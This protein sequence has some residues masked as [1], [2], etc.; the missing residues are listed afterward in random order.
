[1]YIHKLK[2]SYIPPHL[3]SFVL[4]S[5]ELLPSSSPLFSVQYPLSHRNLKWE[6]LCMM[7]NKHRMSLYEGF[8]VVT[9]SE[10]II[11][12][13]CLLNRVVNLQKPQVRV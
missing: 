4:F 3:I 7:E 8:K 2:A 13:D 11:T 5:T 1:M 10:E 12:F 9:S 6:F